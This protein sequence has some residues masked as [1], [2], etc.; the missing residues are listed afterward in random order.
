M[1]ATT[2]PTTWPCPVH[3]AADLFPLIEGQEFKDLVESIRRNGLHEPIEVT[4]DGKLLDGR[5]RFRACLLADVA[6]RFITFRGP[7]TAFKRVVVRNLHRRHLTTSQ[8]SMIAA[9]IATMEQGART[10]LAPN[11]GMSQEEAAA[12]MK[13][14]RRNVQRAKSVQEKGTPEL[15]KAVTDGDISLGAATEVA[16]LPGEEQRAVVK[17][18][19]KGAKPSTVVPKKEKPEA[20]KEPEVT[21]EVRRATWF[22]NTICAQVTTV[23]VTTIEGG[24]RTKF[25]VAQKDLLPALL[26]CVREQRELATAPS[27]E[28]KSTKATTREVLNQVQEVFNRA[29]NARQ[30]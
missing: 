27:L 2:Y 11:G 14:S 4:A 22:L 5:N 10:D 24:K 28:E 23:G 13:V 8:R 18:V 9:R 25:R 12:T 16:A 1:S 15:A 17:Q 21:P 3:E 7:G 19:K 20:S 6:P 29:L 30:P 26:R